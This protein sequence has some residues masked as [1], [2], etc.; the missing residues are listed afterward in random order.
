MAK[1]SK[2]GDKM[3]RNDT[4]KDAREGN[5]VER[6]NKRIDK[7]NKS[8]KHPYEKLRDILRDED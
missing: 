5:K 7:H 6:D 8:D 2:S 4:P 3:G 1:S